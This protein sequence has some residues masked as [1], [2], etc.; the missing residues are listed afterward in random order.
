MGNVPITN[1]FRRRL[2]KNSS[3]TIS[4]SIPLEHAIRLGWDKGGYVDVGLDEERIIITEST[5]RL[6]GA[7]R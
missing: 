7:K 3:G 1:R 6:K 4:V 5:S 2:T